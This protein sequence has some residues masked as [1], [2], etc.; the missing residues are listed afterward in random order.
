V[1]GGGGS[2]SCDNAARGCSASGWTGHWF[3]MSDC[4]Y[5][6]PPPHPPS[7]RSALCSGPAFEMA[8][9]F[10]RGR[11]GRVERSCWAGRN[12]EDGGAAGSVHRCLDR[13]GKGI[14]EHFATL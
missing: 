6:P 7:I 11:V 9:V 14:L 3:P 4:F 5:M 12:R 2:I 1:R 8:G 13:V 10:A